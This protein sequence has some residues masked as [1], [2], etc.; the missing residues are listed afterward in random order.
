MAI[1]VSNGEPVVV[2]V[3]DPGVTFFMGVTV[4]YL[5]PTCSG[6]AVTVMATVG[7]SVAATVTGSTTYGSPKV[8][9]YAAITRNVSI[10]WYIY[11]TGRVKNYC[12]V[13]ITG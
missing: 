9:V 10:R 4:V 6:A 7:P 1:E 11:T 2:S 5:F 12:V 13:V 3:G 8:D